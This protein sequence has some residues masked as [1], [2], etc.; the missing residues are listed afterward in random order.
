[1]IDEREGIKAVLPPVPETEKEVLK[2]K[3]L[4][5]EPDE[6]VPKSSDDGMPDFTRNWDTRNMT[7]AE[8]FWAELDLVTRVFIYVLKSWVA[9]PGKL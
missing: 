4:L 2:T 1:M 5:Q 8:E 6:T 7:L 3:R 9:L